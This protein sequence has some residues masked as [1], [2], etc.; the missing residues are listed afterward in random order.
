MSDRILTAEEAYKK[1]YMVKLEK[2]VHEAPPASMWDDSAVCF[3][4][5]FSAVLCI[6]LTRFYG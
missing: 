4:V 3:L 5:S 1:Y 6:G 2:H